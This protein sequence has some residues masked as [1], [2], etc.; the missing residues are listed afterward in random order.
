VVVAALDDR[1]RY[2][3]ADLGSGGGDYTA[4]PWRSVRGQGECVERSYQRKLPVEAR[5]RDCARMHDAWRPV[6]LTVD[7]FLA[8]ALPQGVAHRAASVGRLARALDRE[9]ARL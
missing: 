4:D 9:L 5:R 2:L 7:D 8:L 3:P 6:M 1:P